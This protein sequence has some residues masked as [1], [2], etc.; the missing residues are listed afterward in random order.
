MFNYTHIFLLI[1]IKGDFIKTQLGLNV[2]KNH[3][4]EL[5]FI[6]KHKIRFFHKDKYF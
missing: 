2:E 6:L 1:L 5:K 4:S 3:S